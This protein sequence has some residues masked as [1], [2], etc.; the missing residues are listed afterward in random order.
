MGKVKVSTFAREMGTSDEKLLEQLRAAGVDKHSADQ[1]VNDEDKRQLLAYLRK[2]HGGAEEEEEPAPSKITLKRRSSRQVKQSFSHGRSRTVEVEVRKKRTFVKRRR[3]EELGEEEREPETVE[4]EAAELEME[5]AG[6]GPAG[7][8]EEQEAP[9]APEEAEAEAA[10]EEAPTEEEAAPAEQGPAAPAE[11][12]PAQPAEP[13]AEQ[14]APQEA[15]APEKAK[16]KKGRKEAYEEEGHPKE[17]AEEGLESKKQRKKREKRAKRDSRKR[18]DRRG[19]E[20]PEPQVREV[21]VPGTISVDEL[22]NRLAMKSAELIKQLFKMGVMVTKNDTLDSDTATLVVEELGHKVKHVS[23]EALEEEALATE[24]PQGEARGRPPVVTVMGHVDHGKTSLLDYIRRAKVAA[25]EAGGI[26]QHIGAYHVDTDSGTLVFLDTPGHEAF[27]A[28]RA[29][30][31][32]VTDLVILV[33][34]ADDGIKPQ[35]MEAIDHAKAAGVPIVVAVN[36]CDLPEA[37]PEKVKQEL[38]QHDLIP[39]DWGGETVYVNVSAKNGDNIDNLLEMVGLQSEMLELQAVAEGP[40]QGIVIESKLDRGRGPVATILVREGL[41]QQGDVL[42][43]GPE[44]GRVRALV[45]EYGENV[46]SAGPSMP[47]EVLGLSGVPEAGDDA[48]VVT[49]ERKAREISEMRHQRAKEQQIAANKRAKLEGMF[50]QMQQGEVAELPILL[51]AD[52]QGSVEALRESLEKLSN[53]EVRVKVIHAQ[54]GGIN[55]SDVNLALASDAIIIGFNVR[56]EASARRLIEQNGIDV[57][58]FSVIYEAVDQV[59]AALEGLLEPEVTEEVTG[60]AEVRDLFRVPKMG[61]VAGCQV[62][63][64]HVT[65]NAKVRV[66]RDN[67]VIYNGQLDSLKRFK[68]DVKEVREGYECGMGIKDF[69]DLKLGDV[70]ECY[71]S[72]E[73]ARTLD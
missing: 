18:E 29:R 49:E 67:V 2:S 48:Q 63:E 44:Y 13:A 24:K 9:A 11:E 47:V 55:E 3:E 41:L 60:R 30:G 20:R 50:E 37:E 71:E 65:R 10:A 70:L 7:V 35:T 8:P 15:P 73:T 27:T 58:Y 1:F 43:A 36:K 72:R 31:A 53:D 64:G 69:N 4:A 51:K 61:T 22:S 32:Q 39:E 66:L 16:G 26:T 34:A 46:E 57:R 52:V 59:K 33:V 23:E 5:G 62:V 19:F 56:A 42:L 17:E 40:A 38:S 21:A 25:G 6:A 68:D 45:N 14:P 28:M 12:A 54:V